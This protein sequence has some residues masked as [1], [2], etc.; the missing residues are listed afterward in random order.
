MGSLHNA[1]YEHP[2]WFA[3]ACISWIAIAIWV[4]SLIGWMIQGD[5]DPLFG[6][7]GIAAAFVLGYFSFMPPTEA[8]RP[9][10]AVATVLTVVIF[11]YLR[12][13]LNERALLAIDVEAME[14]AYEMLRE[15]PENYMMRFKLARLLYE[16]GHIESGLA[17][18]AEALAGMPEKLFTEEHRMYGRWRRLNPQANL[19][20]MIPCIDC[21]HPNP[22]SAILC[23]RCGQPYLLD[24][25][26][27]RW[28]GRQFAKKLIAAWI[29]GIIALAGL[30]LASQLPPAAAIATIVLIM[31]AAITLIW[32]A[33]R[34]TGNKEARA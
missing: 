17:I 9:F 4:M 7:A 32:L 29:A 23:Q 18:G 8:L 25:A 24:M 26:R 16:R 21:G 28:V 11:P 12:R 5:I 6:V 31:A 22:L 10:T 2:Q 19:N 30:P 14:N 27:G 20:K 1:I 34:D 15:K 13:T 3:I 33:F